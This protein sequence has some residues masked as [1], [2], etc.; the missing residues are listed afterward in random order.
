MKIIPCIGTAI[1]VLLISSVALADMTG[2]KD[3]FISPS[4]SARPHTWWHWMNDNV[5]KEEITADRDAA[6][7]S[8]KGPWSVQFTNCPRP[9]KSIVLSKLKSLSEYDDKD[10]Q[11]FS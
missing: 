1:F 6:A 8:L 4:D 9:P 11:A 3:R 10:I 5:T 7:I 2:V